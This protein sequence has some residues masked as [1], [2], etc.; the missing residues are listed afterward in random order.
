M[1]AA[2]YQFTE[3]ERE[4]YRLLHTQG[5]EAFEANEGPAGATYLLNRWADHKLVRVTWPNGGFA[6][7]TF[8]K[9]AY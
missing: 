7:H 1:N 2:D 3:M 4:A 9:Y 6:V 8:K 5:W